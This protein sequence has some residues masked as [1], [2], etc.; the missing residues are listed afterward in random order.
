MF[1]KHANAGISDL[2]EYTDPISVEGPEEWPFVVQE[3]DA[4][5]AGKHF[6][7]RLGEPHRNIVHSFALPKSH[8]PSAGEK[9]LAIQGP[10]HT[11]DALVIEGDIPSG[12]GSGTLKT[13]ER[14]IAEVV[15]SGPSKLHFNVY[16]GKDTD[17]YV[18]MKVPR[19]G[20]HSWLLI[21]VTPTPKSHPDAT[22]GKPTYKTI[23][24]KNIK[25][26]DETVMV[27]PKVSG[28]YTYIVANKGRQIRQ[29]SHRKS[30]R[31]NELIQHT[32]RVPELVNLKPN[33]D[34]VLKSELF[35][36]DSRGKAVAE[37]D[38]SRLLNSSVPKARQMLADRGWKFHN[39]LFDIVSYKGEDVSS[40]PYE[41]RYELISNIAKY[42]PNTQIPYV[43][44]TR[45][46][47]QRLMWAIE[48][49]SFP[50]TDE[51]VI[52]WKAKDANT[53]KK[54]KFTEDESVRIT[55]IDPGKKGLE[56]VGAGGFT[57]KAIVG[58][59]GHVGSGFTAAQRK[60]MF[61]NPKSWIG[62]RAVIKSFGHSARGSRRSPVFKYLH[63]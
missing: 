6:D 30:K 20:E 50:L 61:K 62:R 13:K 46:E 31:R 54:I 29:F 14:G 4:D 57:Y 18:M 17:E 59:Q 7:L 39:M 63:E 53:P 47:K 5:V 52:V 51:G 15:G 34:A 23:K 43:A 41:A 19:Y 35:V 22:R 32:F 24:S 16:R 45:E 40:K 11:P 60:D 26:D 37:K 1:Q 44:R 9:V 21:N 3:H 27:Q 10:I 42:L 8:L 55:G 48:S 36:V 2:G 38:V 58:G 56:G 12:Y 33:F 49:K 25:F 28:A